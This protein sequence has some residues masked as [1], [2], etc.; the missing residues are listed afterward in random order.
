MTAES[1]RTGLVRRGSSGVR[2]GVCWTRAVR[3]LGAVAVVLGFLGSSRLAQQA[4]QPGRPRAAR[5]R[6]A[7]AESRAEINEFSAVSSPRAGCTAVGPRGQPVQPG[8]HSAQRW[9]ARAGGSNT[10]LPNGAASSAFTEV[11]RVSDRLHCR[12]AAIGK[13]A[14]SVT[15]PRPGTARAGESGHPAPRLD[16]QFAV[17]GVLHLAERL[18]RRRQ[19][20]QRRRSPRSPWPNGGTARPGAFSPA[21][22]T[23][24]T[25]CSAC[26]ARARG[27]TAVGYQTPVPGRSASCRGVERRHVARS[28]WCRCRA[29]PRA[30]SWA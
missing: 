7:D 24:V 15:W 18:H 25:S 26:R 21:P 3:L 14:P 13:A 1:R 9:N 4:G 19:L 16:R 28:G 30:G 2:A 29:K 17:R 6:S 10:I 23:T 11:L 5:G 27:R 22:V 20:R 12:G 8:L